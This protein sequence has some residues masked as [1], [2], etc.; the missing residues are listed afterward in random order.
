M[1]IVVCLDEQNGMLFNHR[2][3]SRDR[4]VIDDIVKTVENSTGNR[5]W[6]AEYSVPLF[7]EAAKTAEIIVDNELLD[8]A[9]ENDYCF[10]ENLPLKGREEAI[11][12]VTV[13]RWNRRYPADIQLDI[14]LEEWKLKSSTDLVGYS[15][16]RI[17]KEIY[18]R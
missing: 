1:N 3:Q 17:T 14:K 4:A 7:A 10:I 18:C 13:Y 11:R 8:R 6:I 2:R 15:H 12:S 9:A 5:L 16:E